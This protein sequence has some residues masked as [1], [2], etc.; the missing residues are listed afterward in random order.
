M[1][2][3]YSAKWI[4]PSPRVT[5]PNKT[6]SIYQNRAN[7]SCNHGKLVFQEGS[8]SPILSNVADS[9]ILEIALPPTVQPVN[10][11]CETT[12]ILNNG[13]QKENNYDA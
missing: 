6:P 2:P 5:L 4:H 11:S 9:L 10:N 7:G 3:D 8:S 13:I 12:T 1:F